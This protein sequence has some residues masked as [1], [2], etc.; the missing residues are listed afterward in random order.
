MSHQAFK[1]PG[2]TGSLEAGCSWN[3]RRLENFSVHLPTFFI[4]S[5]ITC[6]HSPLQTYLAA[7][8]VL[9]IG[10]EISIVMETVTEQH[11]ASLVNEK[12]ISDEM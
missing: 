5:E 10:R 12:L 7:M 11:D 9:S 6:C 4:T 2:A 3:P 8:T 1:G